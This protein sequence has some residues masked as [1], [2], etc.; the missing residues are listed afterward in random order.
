MDLR[1]TFTVPASPEVTWVAFNDIEG[2]APCFPGAA[3][4]SVDGDAFTG[5]VKVKLGPIAMQYTGTG[6][7]LERDEVGRRAV[8]QAKGKDKRGNG[9]AVATVV[10][11]LS[12]DGGGTSVVVTTDLSITGKPAQF[13]RGVI[14]EISDKLL[15]QFVDCIAAQLQ[16]TAVASIVESS[17]A[18]AEAAVAGLTGSGPPPAP[19]M[20]DPHTVT[21]TDIVPPPPVADAMPRPTAPRT[22]PQHAAEL[23]LGSTVLPV[24]LKR[25]GPPAAAAL[26]VVAVIAWAARR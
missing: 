6:V 23:D 24:L 5:T 12:P 3:L 7:F 20:P 26:A 18:E 22:A 19:S 11:Q 14:Q 17:L 15:G 21:M 25:Y 10:A 8:L 16:S 9:T 1:H 4:T 13:G 2:I